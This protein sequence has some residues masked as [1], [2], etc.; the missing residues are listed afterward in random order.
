MLYSIF[1][2]K[3][4]RKAMTEAGF[5]R[6]EQ[7]DILAAVE[8]ITFCRYEKRAI[9]EMTSCVDHDALAEEVSEMTG[10]EFPTVL[11]VLTWELVL[12]TYR[13]QAQ[14]DLE[15]VAADISAFTDIEE[16]IVY[17]I[18]CAEDDVY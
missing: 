5:S 12:L 18:L 3:E 6:S 13:P 14:V 7:N 15:Q 10:V 11:D 4:L 17:R 1:D 8:D 16:E 2:Q 9:R